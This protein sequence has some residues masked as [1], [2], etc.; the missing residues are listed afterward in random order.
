[1]TTQREEMCLHT[2]A[3]QAVT[4][5]N[6]QLI[7]SIKLI[8]NIGININTI[9]RFVSLTSAT[10]NGFE[11]ESGGEYPP[12]KWDHVGER[13]MKRDYALREVRCRMKV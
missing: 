13:K 11:D 1:M 4:L 8:A 3:V 10:P 6:R 5:S 12:R 7:V 9:V 2:R